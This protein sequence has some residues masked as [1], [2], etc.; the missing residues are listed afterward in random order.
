MLTTRCGSH[1]PGV[2]DPI[3]M[4]GWSYG[5]VI[6][7]DFALNHPKRVRSLVLFEP[8]SFWIAKEKKESPEGI[9]KMRGHTAGYISTAIITEDDVQNFR[10]GLSNYDSI[11]IKKHPQWGNMAETKGQA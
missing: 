9:D 7:L 2:K 4:V 6:A 5:A 3:V 1:S 8:P 11:A 10:C